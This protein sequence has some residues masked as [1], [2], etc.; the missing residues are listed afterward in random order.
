MQAGEIRT[1]ARLAVALTPIHLIAGDFRQEFKLLFFGPEFEKSRADHLRSEALDHRRASRCQLGLD[2]RSLFAIQTRT[3]VFDRPFRTDPT[4]I[5]ELFDPLPGN[6][7]A[8]HRLTIADTDFLREIF[9][10][11][12]Y[13]FL[14][15]L[16]DGFR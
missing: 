15:K 14:A 10:N 1:R 16:F 7:Q 12:A 6:R 2:H 9:F 8:H 4:S 5:R 11:P 3:A 13:Y